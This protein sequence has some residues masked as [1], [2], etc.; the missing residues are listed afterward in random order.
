MKGD[1]VQD[2]LA[3]CSYKEFRPNMGISV[4]ISL[5][6]PRW[7]KTPPQ[8]SIW[9]LTPRKDYLRGTTDDEYISAFLQQL[10]T[11][12]VETIEKQFQIIHDAFPGERLVLLCFEDLGKFAGGARGGDWCHRSLF[13]WWW[14]E[15]TGEKIP[16]LGAVVEGVPFVSDDTPR[17]EEPQPPE[18]PLF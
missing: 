3:T 14:E 12:G 13:S 5:G 11:Y 16:E 2:R 7:W 10:A 6:G 9:A 15:Q 8:A 1:G 17:I 4:R 18:Q